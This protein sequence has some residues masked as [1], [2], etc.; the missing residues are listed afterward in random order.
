MRSNSHK[1]LESL[2]DDDFDGSLSLRDLGDLI[3]QT[4]QSAGQII[5]VLDKKDFFLRKRKEYKIARVNEK[6]VAGE[7]GAGICSFLWQ[8]AFEKA[9]GDWAMVQTLNYDFLRWRKGIKVSLDKVYHF[10]SIYRGYEERGEAVS[11]QRMSQE[12]GLSCPIVGLKLLNVVGK[13]SLCWSARRRVYEPQKKLLERA[14]S[15]GICCEDIGYFVA[16]PKENVR[17][18]FSRRKIRRKLNPPNIFSFGSE[19]GKKVKFW[20]ASMAYEAVDKEQFSKEELCEL[21]TGE[22]VPEVVDYV[23]EHRLVIEPQICAMLTH[24]YERKIDVP[25]LR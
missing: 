4:R 11:I 15:L 9:E 16:L 1:K 6:R 12:A 19:R 23:L 14:A 24:L 10:Y 5:N 25:Y 21:F 2:I 20:V 22:A 13:K 18:F 8:K 17:S 3:G 7:S